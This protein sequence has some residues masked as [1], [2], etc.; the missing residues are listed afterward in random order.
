MNNIIAERIALIR[1]NMAENGTDTYLLT[2]LNPHQ[3]EYSK[4]NWNY[5]K[6]FSGFTGSA[7]AVVITADKAAF[8]TD[9]RYSLQSKNELNGSEYIIYNTSDPGCVTYENFI[10]QNTK[11]NGVVSF[12]ERTL[13][14][15]GAKKLINIAVSRGIKYKS[16]VSIIEKSL[17]DIEAEAASES[18]IHDIKYCGLSRGDKLKQVREK[19][20]SIGANTYVI[21][22]LED[23]AWL[24]N[25]R[26]KSEPTMSFDAYSIVTDEKAMLFMSKESA[27]PIKA[28]LM[29]DNIEIYEYN[30][31][32]GYIPKNLD[33]TGSVVAFAPSKTCYALYSVLN[34]FKTVEIVV[35]IT[36]EFKTIKNKTEIENT[37]RFSLIDGASLVKF[38]IWVKEAAKTEKVTEYEAGK[39]LDE[40]RAGEEFFVRPSFSTILGYGSNGSI[41]HYR[42]DEAKSLV[43]KPEGFLLV[44]SG[45]NYLGATTDITR[46]IVLGQLSDEMKNNFTL[47]LKSHIALAKAIFLKGTSGHYLDIL[48][49]KPLWDNMLDYKHGTGHGIGFALSVHEGPQRIANQA[50]NV[51]IM[52]GM[53]T[54]NEPGYYKD[55]EYGIRSENII[56]AVE[57]GK[58]ESG[59]FYSFETISFAPF[60]L[61]AVNKDLMTAEEILRLNN[62][63]N[64]VYE[65]LSPLLEENEVRWLKE[66]TRSI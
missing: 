48:A 23:I 49:R 12:D 57:H 46:T 7:G 8:W 5:V 13:S 38:I 15:E 2:K 10:T 17:L 16:G 50:N 18:F 45:G 25:V 44:D 34:E 20:T 42:A 9:G 62:Y 32:Y 43:I 41:I 1:K 52:P 53:L 29:A 36:S 60:D 31:I 55:N 66:A 30:E 61:E 54:S 22:S 24:Y 40:I 27:K 4:N 26:S 59:E 63:H 6:Y 33:K 58:S 39:R 56:L 51:P 28:E 3:S 21:S 11:E 64:E 37:K 35:D 47:V 14:V 19:M 65:K